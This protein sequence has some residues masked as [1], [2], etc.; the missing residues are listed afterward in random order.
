MKVIG[1]I[2]NPVAGMGGRVG[3]KGTDGKDIL[4]KAK[5]L[6][7]I[8]EAPSKALKALKRLM[9]IQEQILV[10]TSS[11]DMGENQCKQLGLKYE[12]VYK[13]GNI[14]DSLDTINAA[15]EMEKR[16]VDL[17]LLVGGDGTARDIYRAV[18]NRVVAL[19]IPAGVKIHSPVY[20]NTPELAG[21]LALLYLR[22]EVLTTKEEEVVDIDEEA[23]RNNLVRTTLLDI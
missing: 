22:D 4:A 9:D 5:K 16:E 18:E 2:I 8:M 14:T 19:G 6:G 17:I 10:L 1:L 23:F 15:I 3:L 13:T 12:V 20:G 21:E 11:G 7:A